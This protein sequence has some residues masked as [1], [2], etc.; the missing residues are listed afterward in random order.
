MKKVNLFLILAVSMMLVSSLYAS[1]M[2]NETK[3]DSTKTVK[4]L[5]HQT[6]CPVMGDKID[7]SSYLDIQGQRVYF[8]CD[9]CIKSFKKDP[10]KYFKEAAEE[11]V[12]FENIQKSCPVSGKE[13]KN[14]ETFV[15]YNGRRVYFCCENCVSDFK[16][17]PAKYLEKLDKPSAEK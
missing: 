9:R 5:A 2:K 10:D 14:K 3:S 7:S 4:E 12:L 15:D 16:A 6:L 11:G 13:L 1:D 17:D 8:C